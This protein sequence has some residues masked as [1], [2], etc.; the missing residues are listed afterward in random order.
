MGMFS[1]LY[2]NVMKKIKTI[3]NILFVSLLVSCSNN[4][5]NSNTNNISS[6]NS[7][8]INDGLSN[9]NVISGSLLNNEDSLVKWNGRYEFKIGDKNTPTVM[10]LYH[11]A[12]GFTIDFY[13]FIRNRKPYCM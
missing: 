4:V 10:F 5:T 13:G 6:S 3:I 11:T 1:I 2:I 8:Q 9:I 7:I 12:T